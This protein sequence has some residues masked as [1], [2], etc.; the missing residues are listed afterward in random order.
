[1]DVGHVVH[2]ELQDLVR[3]LFDGRLVDEISS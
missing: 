3:R 2:A 1:M